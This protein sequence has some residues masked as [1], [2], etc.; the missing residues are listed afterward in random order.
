MNKLVKWL[1]DNVG[2]EIHIIT[3]QFERTTPLEYSWRPETAEQ[4]NSVVNDATVNVLLGLGFRKWDTMNNIIRENMG[5]PKHDILKIP[6]IN[7][8]D[9]EFVID[10]GRKDAPIELLPVDEDILL[11]PGEWY[12]I[13]P[14]GFTVTGLDGETYPF[15]HGESDDDIRFGCLAYG[16]RRRQ[17]QAK[18]GMEKGK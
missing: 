18:Y 2:N 17:I 16:I 5:K 8:P 11:I 10:T 4:F 3:P 7:K 15:K 6:F 13:I 1:K 12:N 9:E 14:D